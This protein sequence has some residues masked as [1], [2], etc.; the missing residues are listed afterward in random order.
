MNKSVSPTLSVVL[1]TRNEE[2]NI[3]QALT[4]LQNWA[5]EIVVVDSG[6]TDH[7]VEIARKLGASVYETD[8]PGFGKQKNRAIELAKSDWIFVLDADERITPELRAEIDD[9]LTKHP[10]SAFN[11]PRLSSYCGRFIRHGGWWPD[12]TI[13]LFRR[14]KARFSDSVVHERLIP[15][16]PVSDLS[17]PLLHH[18][19]PDLESV[20]YKVNHYST[21][22]AQQREKSGRSG[23]LLKAVTR[24]LWTFFRTY[25]LKGAFLD[26]REG[27]MLSVSNAEGTYYTYLKLMYLSE[28]KPG[29]REKE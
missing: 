18:S 5:N 2:G 12:R 15:D 22:G 27:F 13:R 26:G 23:G 10:E 25:I 7:T 8:W 24:G 4:G 19:F 14:G 28:R 9:A 6:S 11:V 29:I 3:E 20:L 21:L 17:S 1:I 16:D